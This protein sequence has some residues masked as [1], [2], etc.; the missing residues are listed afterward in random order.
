MEGDLETAQ[1]FYDKAR[2]AAIRTFGSAGEQAFAEGK[3]LS[4]VATDSDHQ[5]D[6]ELDNTVRIVAGKQVRLN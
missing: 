4:V 5:V 3:K 2:K 1:Y 6:G